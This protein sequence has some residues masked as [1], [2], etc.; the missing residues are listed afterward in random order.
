MGADD[1]EDGVGAVVVAIEEV[2]GSGQQRLDCGEELAVGHF[3][4][5]VAPEHLDRV[6]PGAVGRQVEQHEPARRSPN[7]RLNVIVFMGVSIIPGHVDR[8]GRVVVQQGLEQFGDF[9]PPLVP[10]E[11]HHGF[12]GMVVDRAN[13]VVFGRLGRGG[14]HHLLA[15][16]TPQ[17]FE[18]RQP[19]DIEFVR[20]VEDIARR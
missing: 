6:Q 5:E 15:F 1:R 20:V 19:T 14:D 18:R 7:H 10:P 17:R 12:A 2:A 16:R 9:A 3:A 11:E 8:P 13:A 4:A